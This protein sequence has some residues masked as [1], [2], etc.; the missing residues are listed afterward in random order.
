MKNNEMIPQVRDIDLEL[1][2]RSRLKMNSFKVTY[3]GH[4]AVLT[5]M[6]QRAERGPFHWL[7]RGRNVRGKMS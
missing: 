1:E 7:E 5:G 6:T 4:N 2:E 3:P